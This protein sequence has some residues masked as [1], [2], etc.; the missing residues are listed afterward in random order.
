MAISAR[1]RSLTKR[2][3]RDLGIIASDA[4]KDVIDTMFDQALGAVDRLRIEPPVKDGSK[5][6]RT[7]RA[8]N[9]W[10]IDPLP[11]ITKDGIVVRIFNNVTDKYSGKTY[12]EN[13]FGDEQGNNQDPLGVLAPGWPLMAEEI[14]RGY[15]GRIRK[16][17]DK[18]LKDA[19]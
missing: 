1:L 5:Y 14:R 15:R 7:H 12:A 11:S 16:A 4:V 13:V 6:K 2:T 3:K 8:I 18:A 17:I 19:R 10:G 9:A